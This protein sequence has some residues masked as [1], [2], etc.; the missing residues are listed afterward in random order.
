MIK[1][2]KKASIFLY[3]K[4]IKILYPR[5][6]VLC[7]KYGDIIC[8]KCLIELKEKLKKESKI[9]KCN[10]KSFNE[11][12]YLFKYEKEIRKIIL[13]YKFKDKA[14]LSEFFEK[15]ILKNEKICR[16][17]K[18]YDII[19]P[20]PIHK[21][22]KRE[23]GYNQSEIIVKN[24]VKNFENMEIITKCLIKE[25]NT[26]AQSS[27]S[28]EERKQNVIQVYKIRNRQKIINKKVILFDDIYTTGSTVEECARILK[29]NGASKVLV[30]TIAKD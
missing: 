18:K 8:N 26:V 7:N 27:L 6:C 12:I 3:E 9:E 2:I 5:K 15:I 11:H 29:E 17:L 4:T 23:R 25:K 13:D 24:I 16:N 20:V 30:L 10:N 1:S 19:I 22:R 14:Y 28:K 21:K